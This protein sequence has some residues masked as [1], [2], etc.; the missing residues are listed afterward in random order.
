MCYKSKIFWFLTPLMALV[1]LGVSGQAPLDNECSK[2]TDHEASIAANTKAIR[3]SKTNYTAYVERGIAY[4]ELGDHR[5]ALKDFDHA[6]ELIPKADRAFYERAVLFMSRGNREKALE[7]FSRAIERNPFNPIAY[8]SRG[9]LYWGR[10]NDLTLADFSKA[11]ELNPR[12]AYLYGARA[13][14]MLEIDGQDPAAIA[15]LTKAVELLTAEITAKSDNLCLGNKF[16]HRGWAKQLLGRYDESIA[17][18]SAAIKADVDD[19][20]GYLYRARSLFLQKKYISAAKDLDKA[21]E[22]NPNYAASYKNRARVYDMLHQ[23]ERAEADR[24]KF[25]ELSTSIPETRLDQ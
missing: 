14:A 18:F 11:F 10:E 13:G 19:P 8:Y 12:A 20:E 3:I 1:C 24:Q 16:S 23:K 4:R 17:D 22:L 9:R 7:D 6:I 15:D 5:A 2:K 21:I 25:Q